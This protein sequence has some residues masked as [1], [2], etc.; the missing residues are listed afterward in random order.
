MILRGSPQPL[1]SKQTTP[2]APHRN[3]HDWRRFVVNAV[4]AVDV[5]VDVDGGGG[6]AAAGAATT[7]KLF[8]VPL[9]A[10]PEGRRSWQMAAKWSMDRG[11][12]ETGDHRHSHHHSHNHNRHWHR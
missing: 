10:F 11:K 4:D 6:V 3:H 1:S 7:A 2:E 9:S 8:Q 12:T 5:V